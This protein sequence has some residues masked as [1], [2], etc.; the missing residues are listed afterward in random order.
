MLVLIK[1]IFYGVILVVAAKFLT[2][3]LHAYYRSQKVKVLKNLS[4][5]GRMEYIVSSDGSSALGLNTETRRLCY[6]DRT[7]RSH[8]I[9]PADFIEGEMVV[10]NQIVSQYWGARYG[11]LFSGESKRITRVKKIELRVRVNKLNIPVPVVTFLNSPTYLSP[12]GT[13]GKI[14]K[15]AMEKA[16]YWNE[17]LIILSKAG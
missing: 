11:P 5:F 6:V 8:I 10:D 9:E 1:I 7:N 16:D 14:C 13:Q 12:N 15:A 3:Y 17:K 4:G 2:P